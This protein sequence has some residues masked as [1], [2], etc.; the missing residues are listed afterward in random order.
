MWSI[1]L[2][3]TVEIHNNRWFIS[4][5]FVFDCQFESAYS[6]LNV[7]RLQFFAYIFRGFLIAVA[8]LASDIEAL[9]RLRSLLQLIR[10]DADSVETIKDFKK[11]WKK[12]LLLLWI[13]AVI[14]RYGP[15]WMILMIFVT[16]NNFQNGPGI[17]DRLSPWTDDFPQTLRQS[18]LGFYKQLPVTCIQGGQLSTANKIQ[19]LQAPVASLWLN[20]FQF[21]DS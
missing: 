13:S 3:I 21:F 12:N 14:G 11:I 18:R 19:F 6:R 1:L 4:Y 16:Q 10:R 9:R 15:H 20:S 2:P 17:S 7:L 8:C 5:N